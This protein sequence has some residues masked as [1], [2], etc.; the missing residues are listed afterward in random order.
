MIKSF[1]IA[2]AM[3]AASAGFAAAQEPQPIN[4]F[5]TVETFEATSVAIKTDAGAT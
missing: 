3:F 5:G 2:G 1:I 4:S